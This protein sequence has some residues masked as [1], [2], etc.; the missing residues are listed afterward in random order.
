MFELRENQS[1]TVLKIS[2]TRFS[3]IQSPKIPF[4]SV[5]RSIFNQLA[6][7]FL[8]LFCR[9][10]TVIVNAIDAESI[11]FKFLPPLLLFFTT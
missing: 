8:A 9:K 7:D 11:V 2:S 10:Q 5:K 1:L 3:Y 6:G 4:I